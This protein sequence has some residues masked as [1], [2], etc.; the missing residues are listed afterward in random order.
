[1]T[2]QHSNLVFTKKQRKRQGWP[3]LHSLGAEE[4]GRV[5]GW[6]RSRVN[7][8]IG[9]AMPSVWRAWCRPSGRDLPART[10][11][12]GLWLLLLPRHGDRSEPGRLPVTK[13]R[14]LVIRVLLKSPPGRYILAG[15]SRHSGKAGPPVSGHC[16]CSAT[17]KRGLVL[18]T[19]GP[20]CPWGRGGRARR[21][22]R[23]FQ[24][25]KRLPPRTTSLP[26]RTVGTHS[27]DWTPFSH[28]PGSFLADRLLRPTPRPRATS[29]TSEDMQAGRRRSRNSPRRDERYPD[30][31]H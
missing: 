14:G 9:T 2:S 26:S 31:N 29:T 13:T 19:R 7:L 24:R 15:V 18:G 5:S 25:L 20:A 6:I 1:M 11:P 12:G 21:Q 23:V 30:R 8:S 4:S 17:G 16:G 28:T 3:C 22:S 27:L 10:L